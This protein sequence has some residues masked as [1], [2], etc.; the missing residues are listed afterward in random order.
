M[1][2][3]R[4]KW[5]AMLAVLVSPSFPEQAHAS[6]AAFQP[7]LA[8]IPDGA[9]TQRSLHAVADSKRRQSVP[10]LDELRQALGTWWRDYGGDALR[11]R[12]PGDGLDDMDRHWLRY[13][14]IRKAEHFAPFRNSPGGADHV[15]SLVRQQAPRVAAM[16]T[17]GAA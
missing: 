2:N 16:I 11:L 6:L 13:W 4:P 12:G 14:K 9:F 15:L 8:D 17:E 3:P 1:S 5:L 7:F 10:S